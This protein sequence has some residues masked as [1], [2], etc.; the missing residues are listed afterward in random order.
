MPTI[1][2]IVDIGANFV[3]IAIAAGGKASP[4]AIR[5]A[6]LSGADWSRWPSHARH[7][8]FAIRA[9]A[10]AQCFWP[11]AGRLSGLFLGHRRILVATGRAEC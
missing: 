5:L 8:G 1:H 2:V 6:M 3:N 7:S 9:G 4:N 11:V 10:F